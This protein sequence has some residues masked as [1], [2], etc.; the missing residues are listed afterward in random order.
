MA[1]GLL[2]SGGTGSDPWAEDTSDSG[3]TRDTTNLGD[4]ANDIRDDGTQYDQEIEE[5]ASGADTND[6]TVTDHDGGSSN[7]GTTVIDPDTSE[8]S[9][10]DRVAV[11][12][13]D[14][15]TQV[16]T[17]DGQ[18]ATLEHPNQGSNSGN[19][20]DDS[21]GGASLEDPETQKAALAL[22]GLAAV[23]WRAA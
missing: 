8:D 7:G 9:T 21:G 16:V 18:S 22:L 2:D 10:N 23:A 20:S 15:S 19:N 14:D 3:E 4:A 17:E 1:T 6:I 13:S 12:E 5:S 11:T